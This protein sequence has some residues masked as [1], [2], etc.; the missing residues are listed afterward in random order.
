MDTTLYK[1]DLDSYFLNLGY[2]IQE[3]AAVESVLFDSVMAAAKLD[4][5]TAKVLLSG[6]KSDL[7]RKYLKKLAPQMDSTTLKA[8]DHFGEITTA[9][10]KILHNGVDL[11]P[12]GFFVKKHIKESDSQLPRPVSG[13][14]LKNL[15]SDT[16]R[17]RG[18]IKYRYLL[19]K[20]VINDDEAYKI[21]E[22]H[23]LKKSAE[24]TSSWQYKP[25]SQSG[26][27]RTSQ[28]NNP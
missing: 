7:L 15:T 14:I 17:V 26:S 16:I 28:N 20:D 5:S 24:M 23:V 11:I 1:N 6:A 25:P 12:E 9:R 18:I 27:R 19:S 4:L 22:E 2:F 10:N 13:T 3:F 8:L 21:I